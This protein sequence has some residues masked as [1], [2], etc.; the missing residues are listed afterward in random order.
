MS[1]KMYLALAIHN[2][3][4]VGNFDFVFEKAYELSYLPM[5]EA[6]E[7]HPSIRLAIHNTGPLLDWLVAE[8]PD[9]IKRL[10]ALVARGQIE[11][12]GGGYY[13]PIL[14]S[15]PDKDKRGQIKKLASS[16]EALFD[17]VPTGGWLAERVWEPHLPRSLNRANVDYTIVD[18]TH[19][20][21]AGL[22]DSEMLGYYV[23]EE[24]GFPLKVFATAKH[25]RYTVPWVPVHEVIDWLREQSE[26]DLPQYNGLPRVAVMGDDGEKFGLWPGTFEHCWGEGSAENRGWV[27]NFFTAI[28]ENSDWLET[29]PPGEYAATKPTLG[30]VYIPAASYDEMMEW[31]LPPHSSA[32]LQ[33]AKQHLQNQ[34]D[35]NSLKYLKGGLW[36][37]FMARYP[38]VNHMHKKALWVSNRVHKMARG[39]ARKE[40]RNQLWAA[41]CNCGYWHGL[42]GGSYLFHIRGANYRNLIAAELATVESDLEVSLTDFTRNGQPDIVID[43]RKQ[44]LMFDLERGGALAEWDFRDAPY[45]LL[46]TVSRRH[47]AY[48]DVLREA[49]DHG[50]TRLTSTRGGEAENPHHAPVWVKEG[51]LDKKL[52]YDWYRR[53]ALQDRFLPEDATAESYQ[54][55]AGELGDFVL[56]RYSA[57]IIEDAK[58]GEVRLTRDG[59][60]RQGET[61]LPVSVSKT[62][63]CKRNKNTLT[64]TYLVENKGDAMLSTRFGIENNYGLEGGQDGLTYFD[65][66]DDERQYPG[67]AGSASAVEAFTLTSDISTVGCRIETA[68][69]DS[70]EIWWFPIET[71]TNSEDGYE[72]NYQ[73]TAL[74]HSWP[75]RLE[76]G[77]SWGVTLT[78][79]LSTR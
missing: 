32:E 51:G 44:W 13:E 57:E 56:G 9:Y 5:L 6:L 42:F 15:L 3:Q 14:I 45:N 78:F 40:A 19:M 34:G 71:V 69:S 25:L 37:S 65:G 47:E 59:S 49:L 61:H 64:V 74:L 58:Y 66:L 67:V 73:G 39:K 29:I 24:Q 53:A 54:T 79:T 11:I 16:V 38:E 50:T 43:N 20:R 18:D 4:P 12:M 28:E 68:L 60:V 41:Q 23:T 2:H 10:K 76:P 75:L 26:R 7:R 70:A 36:R 30:P 55:D 8:R 27:E 77:K 22:D 62:I 21:Y 17:Y 63:H 72:A 52:V 33:Q 31:A 48:H 1:A 35:T 46:N